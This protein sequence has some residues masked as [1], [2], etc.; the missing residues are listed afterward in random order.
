VYLLTTHTIKGRPWFTSE[1]LHSKHTNSAK[2]AFSNLFQLPS[3][4][5]YEF[6]IAS[7]N[8][9]SDSN[10]NERRNFK[11]KYG[12][13]LKHFVT[14]KLIYGNTLR[15]PLTLCNHIGAMY[16]TGG[17]LTWYIFSVV[18]AK[19]RGTSMPQRIHILKCMFGN[20][21]GTKNAHFKNKMKLLNLYLYLQAPNISLS[22]KLHVRDTYGIK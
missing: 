7:G 5:Q 1:I 16:T 8:A 9:Y 4:A 3:G 21:R 14:L 17:Y 15:K 22:S 20:G 10:V 13:K 18:L 11:L 2:W 19:K 12:Y 6:N